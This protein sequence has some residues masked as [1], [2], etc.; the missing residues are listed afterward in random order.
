MT[1]FLSL[2]YRAKRSRLILVFFIAIIVSFLFF[3][4]GS[5]ISAGSADKTTGW[6]WSSSV[7]WT[8][9]NCINNSS[10]ATADYGVDVNT[11]PANK[12]FSGYAWNSNVGWISFEETDA[13]PDAYAFA[14]N[15]SGLCDSFAH[16]TACL[17]PETG[18]IWGWAKILSLGNDGWIKLRDETF[19]PAYGVYVDIFSTNGEFKGWAWNGNSDGSG[20]GWISFN[21]ANN[22]SCGTASYAVALNGVHFPAVDNLAA[23]NWNYEDA[24]VVTNGAVLSWDME[25]ADEP[26]DAQT[27]YQVVIN[28]SN[29]RVSPLIDT[30]K[31]MS[32]AE[33]YATTSSLFNYAT[34]YYWWVKVWDSF[35]FSSDWYQFYTGTGSSTLTDNIA[36]NATLSPEPLYTFTTYSNEFPDVSF[37]WLPLEP[38]ANEVATFT[39][40]S[41]IYRSSA[42]STPVACTE[43]LCSWHWSAV[44]DKIIYTPI[45]SLT[46]IVF[47]YGNNSASLNVTG[48]SGYNCTSTN[49]FFV[50][51]LP[52][53][54]EAKPE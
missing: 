16:C 40:A 14:A 27:A 29:T 42:P 12:N 2:N 49:N 6:T 32:S 1:K 8:S 11:S 20:I 10:C 35:G 15:C 4:G 7:G 31:R 25:D 24:C 5:P 48:P 26:L 19:S 45:S 37:A 36:S 50:D 53:W 43:A 41:F 51:I 3:R 17:D 52:T 39:D 47:Q 33:Q 18:K 38:L 23:P 44:G 28:T 34:S 54:R 30:G 9:F 13:P 46:G 21:C 22:S